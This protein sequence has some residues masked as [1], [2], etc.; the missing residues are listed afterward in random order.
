[1]RRAADA[2][3]VGMIA[4]GLA[5]P[6]AG[7]AGVPTPMPL[8]QLEGQVGNHHRGARG[9]RSRRGRRRAAARAVDRLRRAATR[10]HRRLADGRRRCRTDDLREWLLVGGPGA[11]RKVAWTVRLL[12]T[13]ARPDRRRRGERAAIPRRPSLRRRR[14]RSRW[15]GRRRRSTRERSHRH[16]RRPLPR[17]MARAS[18][19]LVRRAPTVARRPA[20]AATRATTAGTIRAA[21]PTTVRTARAAVPTT[22]RPTHAA[23]LLTKGAT[24]GCRR[25]ASARAPPRWPGCSRLWGS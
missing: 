10:A 4:G 13:V 8:P 21:A 7:G 1:M 17:L 15:W 11:G 24:V 5:R 25:A 23:L 12:R 2:L 20:T 3:A 22:A 19:T 9:T 16:R 18:G 14:R 6:V